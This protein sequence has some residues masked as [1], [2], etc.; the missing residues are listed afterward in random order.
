MLDSGCLQAFI[1][2]CET[3]NFTLAARRLKITQSAISQRIIALESDLSAELLDRK[4]RPTTPTPAGEVL[5]RRAHHLLADVAEITLEIRGGKAIG[6][7]SLKIGITEN[8]CRLIMPQ[9]VEILGNCTGTLSVS[10]ASSYEIARDFINRKNHIAILNDPLL[11]QDNIRRYELCWEPLVLVV[12]KE[13]LPVEAGI[14]G[15]KLVLWLAKNHKFIGYSSC[16]PLAS[17][18]KIAL[19]RAAISVEPTFTFNSSERMLEMVRR[20]FGWAISTPL[21]CVGVNDVEDEVFI[22]DIGNISMPRAI[23][24]VSRDGE[25]EGIASSVAGLA[26]DMLRAAALPALASLPKNILKAVN[27][28][29]HTAGTLLQV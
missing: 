12:H 16:S 18:I 27:I 22:G 3:G 20:K 25:F 9:L 29:P 28:A 2:V 23:Y 14:E 15:T 11:R 4:V 8:V 6:W 19:G 13:L 7:P 1:A 26:C 21:C 17:Q 10:V 5:Y 24:L